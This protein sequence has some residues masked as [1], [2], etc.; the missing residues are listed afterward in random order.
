MASGMVFR[1]GILLD[2]MENLSYYS[3]LGV[4]SRVFTLQAVVTHLSHLN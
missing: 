1:L 3:L 2:S 4:R